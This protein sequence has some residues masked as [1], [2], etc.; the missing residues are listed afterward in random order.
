M[1]R[2]AR[3]AAL[4]AIVLVMLLA[5]GGVVYT[6]LADRGGSKPVVKTASVAAETISSVPKPTPPAANAPEGVAI[7]SLLAPVKAGS[8]VMLTAR[9][10]AGS[11]CTITAVYAGVP[12][13]DSGLVPK[14]A[15]AYGIVSW[16]WTVGPAVPAGSWPVT[17]TCVYHG[18]SGVAQTSL[19]VTK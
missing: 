17:V 4:C 19:Q 7:D 5:A 15:D 3:N 12:G 1:K 9:T 16:S 13:K 14:T 11:N 18:R 6:F 8:N 2:T 10:N